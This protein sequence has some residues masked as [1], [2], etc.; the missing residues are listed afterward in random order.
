MDQ[1]VVAGS[2][3]GIY[4]HWPFCVRRCSYCAFVS[5]VDA[6]LQRPYYD[7]L[8]SEIE[9]AGQLYAGRVD[10]IF[11]GGGTPS[12]APDGAIAGL[13]HALRRAFFVTEDAEI[14]I[15]ANP[16]SVNP[17]SVAEWRDAGVSR[18]SIGLQTTQ[19]AHLFRLGRV[20][21][22]SDFE[23]AY[24]SARAGGFD[25][26]NIDLMYGL[27]LQTAGEWRQTLRFV[28]SLQPEHISCYALSLEPG[29][30][31]YTRVQAG[32]L[33]LPDESLSAKMYTYAA[34]TL[35]T[36]GY[37]HYE[38]SNF[39][40]PG[41][42]C[43]HNVK[44]WSLDN[45]LGIGASAH[46]LIGHFRFANTDSVNEYV[47]ERQ[48]GLLHYATY[49]FITPEERENE[50][51]MLKTRLREGFSEAEY[52][53]AFGRDFRETHAEGLEYCLD[54]GLLDLADGRVVPT[55]RGFLFQNQLAVQLMA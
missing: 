8:V 4:V 10:T 7:A 37:D 44:Y 5:S 42:R 19:A 14:T 55:E 21:T 54:N 46:S 32:I 33:P 12:S 1:Q 52:F 9:A 40:R 53:E 15:E 22:L 13:V 36:A 29:T 11:I 20:H 34:H 24:A 18:L 31:L 49:E 51:I 6:D 45:Y 48:D 47:D 16:D 28:R 2:S 41:A 35:R 50:F 38:I 23:K 17:A 26:I 27:P 43:A 30:D 3:L 25:S 39:A